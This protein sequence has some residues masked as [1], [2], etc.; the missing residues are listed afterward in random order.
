[1]IRPNTQKNVLP[2]DCVLFFDSVKP[3]GLAKVFLPA[4]AALIPAAITAAVKWM[5]DHSRK[6]RSAE[7]TQRV[8]A[9]AKSISE[10]PVVPL[11]S[12][13]PTVTPQSA[14]TV[15]LEAV[16]HELTALQK[17]T[18][19]SFTGVSSITSMMRSAF[20]L[21]R[22]RG[23]K[24]WILHLCFYAYLPCFI[25]ILSVGWA[26]DLPKAGDTAGTT[27][28][29]L[30]NLFFFFTVFGI[31]G[32]PPLI[33]RYFAVKIHRKQCALAQVAVPAQEDL[34]AK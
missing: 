3:E 23:L 19:H 16:L 12:A 14:L 2:E 25:F 28:D 29:I 31:L 13:N 1:V 30:F 15:E 22:P 18:V 9:L 6:G 20:L 8:S 26:S 32:I 27:S 21:F 4:F 33:I 24:A 34:A 5:L 7:L 10:L 11:S 17:R